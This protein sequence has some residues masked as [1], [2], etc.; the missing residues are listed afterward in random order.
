MYNEAMTIETLIVGDLDT[1]CYLVWDET[2]RQGIV[3]DPGASA[4]FISQKI[5][6]YKITPV[7]ITLTH[8]HFDHVLGLLELKLNF[9]LPIYLHPADRP[10]LKLAQKSAL[11]WTKKQ[12]DPVPPADKDYKE[13]DTIQFGQSH[14]KI[15]ETPG[16]T[17]GSI[18]LYSSSQSILFSGDTL[19]KQG[20][21]RTDLP[22]SSSN[23]LR[24]SLK[25]L[26]DLPPQTV[27]Y[28]G[29]GDITT[30][31]HEL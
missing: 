9:N 13:G 14:L 27:V 5:L 28:P 29:H 23:D 15:I 24:Q 25:K 16:H 6:D 2:T 4:D 8:A 26:A 10:L 12:V 7:A 30:I 22:Y 21:G 17:P 20:I 3:I 19:F 18:C 11:W 1:N 31:G